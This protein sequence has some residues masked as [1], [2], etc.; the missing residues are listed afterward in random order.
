MLRELPCH[1]GSGFLCASLLHR[2]LAWLPA[3]R[4]LVLPHFKSAL[5]VARKHTVSSKVAEAFLNFVANLAGK[6]GVQ[7]PR[8]RLHISVC[9]R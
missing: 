8:C 9:H 4:P 6:S 3:S 1:V 2:Y 7:R 5:T